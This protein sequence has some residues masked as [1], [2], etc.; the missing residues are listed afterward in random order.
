MTL[1]IHMEQYPWEEHATY[2]WDEM[3]G[4]SPRIPVKNAH[5][6]YYGQFQESHPICHPRCD[7][8]PEYSA[9][10]SSAFPCLDFR[11]MLVDYTVHQSKP[12][13]L[14]SGT[15]FKENNRQLN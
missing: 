7:Y 15:I 9:N 1:R 3:N 10:S 2:I 5:N 4:T 6:Y 13:P 14:A 12:F 11:I 8:C